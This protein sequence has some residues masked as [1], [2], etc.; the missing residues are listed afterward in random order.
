M[1]GLLLLLGG[2]ALLFYPFVVIADL[3]SLAGHRD[4]AETQSLA[5]MHTLIYSTLAYPV[6]Y[7]LCV[8][9]TRLAV[10]RRHNAIS[11]VTS[12]FPM[13]YV[14]LIVDFFFRANSHSR[15]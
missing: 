12:A 13:I 14:T 3:M 11:I 2:V 5:V 10:S 6:V 7:V 1:S 15:H 4:G 8:V 9:L